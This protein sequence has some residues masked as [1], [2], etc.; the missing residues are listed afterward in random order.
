MRDVYVIGIGMIRFG[1]YP[2]E[3]V[4]TMAEKA[5]KLALE[6]SQLER[7]DFRRLFSPTLFGEC[8]LNNTR[9]GA[10]SF[11]GEWV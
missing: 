6:D 9:F 11:S 1:K 8:L 5:V 3:T 10:R 7:K 2:D 4:R